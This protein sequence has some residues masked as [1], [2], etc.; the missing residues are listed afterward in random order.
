MVHDSWLYLNAA[1]GLEALGIDD[2]LNAE[3]MSRTVGMF[4]QNNV[5]VR[6]QSP[7]AEKVGALCPGEDEVKFWSEAVQKIA[8]TLPTSDFDLY[9]ATNG[10]LGHNY[11]VFIDNGDQYDKNGDMDKDEEWEEEEREEE[12]E[13]KRKTWT[14]IAVT[15]PTTLSLRYS[16]PMKTQI[17]FHPW[18]GQPSI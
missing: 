1:L 3:Y 11:C 17:Y 15:P 8:A 9:D 12:R 10:K 4:E 13:R 16:R 7:L 2:Y 14:L 6:L 5:G 18:M